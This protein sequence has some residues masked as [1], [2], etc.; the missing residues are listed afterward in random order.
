MLTAVTSL[1]VTTVSNN[2]TALLP[3]ESGQRGVNHII[4]WKMLYC[5]I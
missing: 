4:N 5:I 1:F 3:L 2:S